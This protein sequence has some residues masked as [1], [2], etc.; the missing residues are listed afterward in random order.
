MGKTTLVQQLVLARIGARAPE[1]VGLPVTPDTKRRVLYIAA[2]RPHQVA[3]SLRRMVGEEDRQVLAERLVVWRGPLPF[4]VTREPKRLATFAAEHQAGTLVIDSLKDIAVGLA[5]DEVGAQVNLAVQHVIAAGIEL[6]GTH[7]QR[8]AT[9][10]NQRPR[11][12]ADVYGSTWITAG[13]G[14]VLLLWGEPGD[15]LVELHHLKQ[16]SGE[17]GPLTLAHDHATGATTVHEPTSITA[18]LEQAPPEGLEVRAAASRVYDTVN[19]SRAQVEK[20]R[21]RL[22]QLVK[23]GRAIE[24]PGDDPK[25]AS[26]FRP[27]PSPADPRDSRDSSRDGFTPPI[28]AI[29]DAHETASRARHGPSRAPQDHARPLIG[30]ACRERNSHEEELERATEEQEAAY[31]RGLSLIDGNAA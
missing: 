19:P 18:L 3:R 12:L 11:A 26:T 31:A 24:V 21:R 25:D 1:V 13:A 22:R 10:D 23:E 30:G 5:S 8:K 28:T 29:T 9:S 17:V 20:A 7:H 16:P 2:D 27:R 6:L 4:D 15:P 14:S